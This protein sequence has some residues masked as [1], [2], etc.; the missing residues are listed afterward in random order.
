MKQDVLNFAES[1]KFMADIGRDKTVYGVYG[2]Y[3]ALI[4]SMRRGEKGTVI[5]IHNRFKRVDALDC[6]VKKFGFVEKAYIDALGN[7]VINTLDKKYGLVQSDYAWILDCASEFIKKFNIK[8][9]GCESCGRAGASFFTDTKTG[10]YFHVCKKC[11]N[12]V[13]SDFN[14]ARGEKMGMGAALG[15]FFRDGKKTQKH[16]VELEKPKG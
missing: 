5:T 10:E 14:Q 12:S 3:G 2:Y 7:A 9:G 4:V 15:R 6:G 8:T 16:L 11:L 1:N 13:R